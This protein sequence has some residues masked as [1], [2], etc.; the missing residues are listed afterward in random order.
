MLWHRK[1]YSEVTGIKHTF[2]FYE[3]AAE[4]LTCLTFYRPCS[5]IFEFYPNTWLPWAFFLCRHEQRNYTSISKWPPQKAAFVKMYTNDNHW[6]TTTFTLKALVCKRLYF[7][8]EL[9]HQLICEGL[10]PLNNVDLH[11]VKLS[12]HS[13]YYEINKVANELIF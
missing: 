1:C 8:V 2:V 4:K 5:N 3:G 12:S 13:N 9:L 11:K 6:T 10:K 7:S